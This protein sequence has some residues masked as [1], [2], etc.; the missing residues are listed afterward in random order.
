[1]IKSLNNA[2]VRFNLGRGKNYM[3]WKIKTKDES[4]YIDPFAYSLIMVNAT[5]KNNNNVAK[6]IN[7]GANKSVCSWVKCDEVVLDPM[8]ECCSL[9]STINYNPRIAPYWRDEEGNNI[10]GFNFNILITINKQIFTL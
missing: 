6:K 3:K 1:M 2:T 4:V 8:S 5:L 10:D 9:K 7:E